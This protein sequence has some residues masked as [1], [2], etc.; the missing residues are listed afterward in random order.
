MSRRVGSTGVP[1]RVRSPPVWSA[2]SPAGSSGSA[3][4][5]ASAPAVDRPNSVP[6]PPQNR[7]F[8]PRGRPH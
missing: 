5:A 1:K 6:Q 2:D 7:A 8:A 4:P 3:A